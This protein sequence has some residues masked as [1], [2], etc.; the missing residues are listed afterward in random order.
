LNFETYDFARLAFGN[1]VE[2][3]ATDLAIGGETLC[4]DAGVEHD[5]EALTAKG[6]L[7]GFGDFHVAMTSLCDFRCR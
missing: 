6:A 1:N 4:R 7:D 2:W 3:P 5:F